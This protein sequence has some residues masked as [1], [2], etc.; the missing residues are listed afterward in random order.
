MWTVVGWRA[1]H[2]DGSMQVSPEGG[3]RTRLVWIT[4]ILPHDL[5]QPLPEVQDT[6]MAIVK[7]TLER[8]A[9]N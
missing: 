6:G 9:G 7:Q 4:D 3:G 1:T 2:H 5:A 8:A